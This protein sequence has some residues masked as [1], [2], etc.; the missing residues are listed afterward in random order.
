MYCFNFRI[1]VKPAKN[2]IGTNIQLVEENQDVH[3]LKEMTFPYANHNKC[4]VSFLSYHLCYN[5]AK[6]IAK[7]AKIDSEIQKHTSGL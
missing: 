4:M 2:T 6:V 7:N 5:I 1:G 3:C